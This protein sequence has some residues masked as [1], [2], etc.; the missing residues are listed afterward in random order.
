MQ[1]ASFLP[2]FNFTF[3]PYMYDALKPFLVSHLVLSNKAYV[4]TEF[5]D[6]YFNDNWKKYWLSV[7]KLGQSLLLIIAVGVL[8]IFSNI[9]IACMYYCSK[10]GS[11]INVWSGKKLGEYKFNAYI[12]FYM[13]SYYDLT[14]FAVMKLTQ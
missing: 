4:L 9:V 5:K 14:F 13:L 10:K 8:L 6:W 2:L 11:K 7:A 12:R 1:L 3:I